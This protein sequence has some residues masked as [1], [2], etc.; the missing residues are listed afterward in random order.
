M[1]IPSPAD[2]TPDTAPDT[3]PASPPAE[4]YGWYYEEECVQGTAASFDA[5]M[6]EIASEADL[7][8][9]GSVRV[10]PMRSTEDFL[11]I[12]DDDVVNALCD[13]PDYDMAETLAAQLMEGQSEQMSDAIEDG[14]VDP[15]SEAAIEAL[16]KILQEHLVLTAKPTL[17]E[18]LVAWAKKH[19]QRTP[20]SYC[21]G[22]KAL[23]RAYVAGVW[24][25]ESTKTPDAVITYATDSDTYGV[26]G[27]V[28]WTRG[29]LHTA[30]T[31]R[32]ARLAAEADVAA[33]KL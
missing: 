10:G 4:E 23:P 18:E 25:A 2:T 29:A 13:F 12:D 6:E 11:N 7:D 30:P 20:E 19:A 5:I 14:E 24:Q 8:R 15:P 27:W 3:T 21:D 31:Y 16:Q 9:L 17:T 28:W 26:T 33:R 22:D 1:T 32:D